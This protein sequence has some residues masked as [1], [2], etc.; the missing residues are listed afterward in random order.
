M[1]L[2]RRAAIVVLAVV[3]GAAP[4]AAQAVKLEFHDGK[5]NLT[6]QSASLR[7][8]LTEWARQGGTRMVNVEKIAGAPLTLQ[9]TNVPEIQA[10]DIILR[11][12]AGYVVGVRPAA[13]TPSQSAFDRILLVPTAGTASVVSRPAATP[14]PFSPPVFQPPPP[15][16]DDNPASD[17]PPDDDRPTRRLP[18]PGTPNNPAGQEPPDDRPA[19]PSPA[20][21]FGIAPGS[22]SA[23]PGTISP[24][25][26]Q[27][28]RPRSQP[29]NE[30]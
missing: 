20:N 24:A 17:V 14:P 21:P 13:S 27:T 30:P 22:G 25:P 15:D 19:T 11:G 2:H 18:A 4:A 23:R 16:P 28:Q 7:T 29:D 6:T 10:L 12:T 8:I 5:V 3:C 9:L 26:P 1:S